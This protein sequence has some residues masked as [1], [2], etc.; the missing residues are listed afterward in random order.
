MI[1]TTMKPEEIINEFNRDYP[2]LRRRMKTYLESNNR[3]LIQRFRKTG[4]SIIT[5]VEPRSTV[6]NK[7]RYKIW[8]DIYFEKSGKCRY[9]LHVY[10]ILTDS[11][12]GKLRIWIF[13]PSSENQKIIEFWPGVIEK[14]YPN[15]SLKKSI[16]TFM[17]LFHEY[18]VYRHPESE[19]YNIEASFTGKQLIA[20]GHEENQRFILE[21][22]FTNQEIEALGNEIGLEGDQDPLKVYNL[23]K[24]NKDENLK[25]E[26]DEN[27]SEE[28]KK[29]LEIELAWKEYESI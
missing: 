24:K 20:F 5:P 13:S 7:N 9:D 26:I 29:Q 21:K 11:R 14:L 12:T 23:W 2:E 4:E 22:I 10:Q 1:V 19:T 28:E 15:E 6:I 27:L 8:I 25:I 16:D 18:T 17:K 3:A